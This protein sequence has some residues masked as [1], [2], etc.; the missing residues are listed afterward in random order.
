[1]SKVQ[2]PNLSFCAFKME[3]VIRGEMG[4]GRKTSGAALVARMA[5]RQG[6]GKGEA[7]QVG[8]SSPK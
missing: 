8:K 3:E 2:N 4:S 5:E 6:A 1:M 7:V